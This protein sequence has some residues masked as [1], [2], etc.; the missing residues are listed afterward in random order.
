ME[1]KLLPRTREAHIATFKRCF[2]EQ[3]AHLDVPSRPVEDA[4][5]EERPRKQKRR[6]QQAD[7]FLTA[8]TANYYDDVRYHDDEVNGYL[9]EPS[10]KVEKPLEWWKDRSSQFPRLSR[11]AFDYLSIPAMSS[12]CERL[13]SRAKLCV[14]SQRH[15][16]HA[17]TINTLQSLKNW[18]EIGD[19]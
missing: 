15:S 5:A 2:Q 12:E 9:A 13:F 16:L 17:E 11:M 8:N 3:Y 1:H 18:V 19:L 4:A 10:R 6:A 7:S 14:S